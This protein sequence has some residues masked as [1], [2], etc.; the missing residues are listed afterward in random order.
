MHGPWHNPD[1]GE[2]EYM[3]AEAEFYAAEK[4]AELDRLE[5]FA[6]GEPLTLDDLE[7]W[8]ADM[9]MPASERLNVGRG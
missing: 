5:A 3:L 6:E 1:A 9:S 7:D 4:A 2:R 8:E